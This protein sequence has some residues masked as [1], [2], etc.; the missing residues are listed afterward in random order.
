MLVQADCLKRYP[1]HSASLPKKEPLGIP[2][3][4]LDKSLMDAVD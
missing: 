3:F 4:S 2:I 1:Y